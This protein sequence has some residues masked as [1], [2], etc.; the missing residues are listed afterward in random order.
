[1]V[2]FAKSPLMA[3][4]K[5]FNDPRCPLELIDI[6]QFKKEDPDGCKEL[7]DLCAKYY[8]EGGE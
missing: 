7:G 2:D 4:R 5:Y 6:K 8:A 1:M 3:L